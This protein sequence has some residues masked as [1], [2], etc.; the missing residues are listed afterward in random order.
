MKKWLKALISQPYQKLKANWTTFGVKD[1]YTFTLDVGENIE[2]E[3]YLTQITINF[4][5]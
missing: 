3:G 5:K 4:F 1:G 2:M